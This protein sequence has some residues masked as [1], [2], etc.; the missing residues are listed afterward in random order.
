MAELSHQLASAL[1][2]TVSRDEWESL[3]GL[4]PPTLFLES[5]H[6]VNACYDISQAC[7]LL[8]ACREA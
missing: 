7:L 3:R 2:S 5:L 6:Q 4:H 1:R 8:C